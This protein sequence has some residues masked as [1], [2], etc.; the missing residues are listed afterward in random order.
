VREFGPGRAKRKR[1]ILA[2][3]D[4][5]RL[6]RAG[7]VARL[8]EALCFL[9]AYPDDAGL[10]AQ[11]RRMLR[12]FGRREDVRRHA[13]AL[14]DSGIAGTPIEYRFFA[15]TALWLARRHGARLAVRWHE[16]ERAD[17]LES[18]LP[19]LAHPAETPGLDEYDLGLERWIER[20][21]GPHQTDAAFLIRSLARLR[22]DAATH[23]ALYD[24]L[25][26]PIRMAPDPAAFSRTTARAPVRRVRFQRAPLDRGRPDLAA[27]ALRPPRAV[28][29]LPPGAARRYVDLA[30]EAMVTRSRDLD[31]FAYADPRDVRLVEFGGG[32]QFACLGVVPERRL[33]LE[34]VYGFL[35]LKNGVPTGYVLMSALYGSCEVA[36]NVFETYRGSEAALVYAR[37]IA[38]ARHLLG[39]DAFTIVPYQLGEGND[40]AIESGAWWF[41]YKLGYRPR[42]RGIER[43]VAGELERMRRDPAHR[44]GP[45]TLRRLASD[46][47]FWSLG[48][49]RED[50]IGRI[51]LANVGIAVTDFLARRFGSERRRAERECAREAAAKSGLSSLDGWSASERMAWTRWAPVVLLL[52]GLERW[53]AAERSALVG[54]ARAKG[55]RR[56]SDFVLRFDAH[57]KLRRALRELAE[58]SAPE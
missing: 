9:A 25:D 12:R 41:Y 6:S 30:R 18:L 50:V 28:R 56:E 35:T 13:Q 39:A 54:V 31:A 2:L 58:R 27:E 14:L 57:V 45:A 36:Y 1:A 52:P 42:N 53:T 49:A 24:A 47:V 16:F 46:N 5:A 22:V 4:N 34:S 37:V 29:A 8:H 55:G 38:M 48:R 33:L 44:S 40:E 19:L 7:D 20:M 3:L 23:E 51:P 21:K 32:L 43:L 26:I 17:L 10:L 15:P 11:V